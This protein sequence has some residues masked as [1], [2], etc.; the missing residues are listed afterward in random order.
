MIIK[1]KDFVY[2]IQNVRPFDHPNV[3][4]E[5]YCIDA[6][7]AV[8]IVY[9]AGFEFDDISNKIIFDLGAG[10]GRLSIAC[11]LLN[12][13]R[14]VSVDIDMRALD[15]LKENIHDLEIDLNIAPLCADVKNLEI[16][17]EKLIATEEITTI[18]N[19]P[20]GVQTRTAD[21]VFLK[22]AFSFSNVIYSIHLASDKVQKFI[23]GY[24]EKN[25]WMVDHVYPFNMILEKSFPFHTQRKK[26][27][28]VDVYRF[29]KK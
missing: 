2:L 13:K 23:Q 21:R 3:D 12:A 15:I 14:V 4:L 27:I 7:S 28:Q 1:K 6:R 10:T 5:Q 8:D 16:I 11:A 29:V 17:K 18:M 9:F 20:F 24:A 19:P 22:K 26:Q 25:G